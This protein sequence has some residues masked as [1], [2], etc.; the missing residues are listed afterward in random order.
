MSVSITGKSINSAKIR[1]N[2][3]NFVLLLSVSPFVLASPELLTFPQMAKQVLAQHPSI[4][5]QI[6]LERAADDQVDE[7][8]WQYWPTP[9]VSVDQLASGGSGPSYSGDK[10]V[11]SLGLRQ[12][13]WTGGRLTANVERAKVSANLARINTEGVQQQLILSAIQ[14]WGD[15]VS[16]NAS[17]SAYYKS[18]TVH[19]RLLK[20]VLRRR[21]SGISSEADVVLARLRL[22]SV[23]ADILNAV[24][25]QQT[26]ERRLQFLVGQRVEFEHIHVGSA[27]FEDGFFPESLL[28]EAEELSPQ[29][30]RAQA[31]VKLSDQDVELSRA[32]LLPQISLRLERQVGSFSE[33]GPSGESLV[34]IN[35]T[36]SF[37]GGLSN[38]SAI[39]AARARQSAAITEI[40]TQRL[41]LEE[42]VRQDVTLIQVN[43]SRRV[44]LQRSLVLA[45]SVLDSSERL[46][47]AGRKQWLDLMDSARE[48]TQTEVQLADV[49]GTTQSAGWRLMLLTR[50][51]SAVV[52][53]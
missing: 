10:R 8:K 14:A 44:S 25:R 13:I 16:A 43:S 24:V 2:I 50:G 51:V 12:P 35:M 48:Q 18:K 4:R 42:Q 21:E 46:F 19:E 6:D 37:G 53:P 41:A 22:E 36:T 49:L 3:V 5:N 34:F 26:A 30:A 11:V 31:A 28:R 33:S 1:I 20:L 17:L 27:P 40:E 39:S 29:I 47:L 45:T 9:S 7:A 15:L 38:S 23:Q 52:R 32:E